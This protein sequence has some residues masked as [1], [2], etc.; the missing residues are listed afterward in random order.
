MKTF[1]F[2]L[3]DI[4]KS[5]D[6]IALELYIAKKKQE[7]QLMKEKPKRKKFLGIF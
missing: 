4:E 2:N 1:G 5:N 6:E 7:Q 3:L